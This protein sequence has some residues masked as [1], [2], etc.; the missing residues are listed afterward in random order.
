MRYII[1]YE[2]FNES[3]GISDSCEKVLNEVWL[4]IENDTLPHDWNM[5]D[6]YKI[7]D[8]I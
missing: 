2:N 6:T 8:F 1:K 7:N 3:K 5:Y 4:N